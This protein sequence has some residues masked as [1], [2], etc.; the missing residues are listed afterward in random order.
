MRNKGG[1][2]IISWKFPF[3][4][5]ATSVLL[6]GCDVLKMVAKVGQLVEKGAAH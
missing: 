1:P 2:C 4:G 5:T 6:W 3:V